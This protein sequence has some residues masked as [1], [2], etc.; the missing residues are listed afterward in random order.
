[1]HHQITSNLHRDYTF[2]NS[3][4]RGHVVVWFVQE[5]STTTTWTMEMRHSQ[6]AERHFVRHNNTKYTVNKRDDDIP[7]VDSS[8]LCIRGML[9]FSLGRKPHPQPRYDSWWNL[10]PNFVRPWSTKLWGEGSDLQLFA[11]LADFGCKNHLQISM[12]CICFALFCNRKYLQA[13]ILDHCPNISTWFR[14]TTSVLRVVFT[15]TYPTNV[16]V[17]YA[18][19]L[20]PHRDST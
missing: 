5:T 17:Y 19:S 11:A 16:L 14:C 6:R 9:L 4:Y 8:T 15:W 10:L 1:M 13:Q 18:A 3:V 12:V 7:T 2:V 20:S